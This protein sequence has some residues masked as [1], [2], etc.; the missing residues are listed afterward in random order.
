[1]EANTVTISVKRYDELKEKEVIYDYLKREAERNRYASTAEK[2]LFKIEDKP[3]D[4]D[5]DF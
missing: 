1:M 4:M 5:D 2:L 3:V